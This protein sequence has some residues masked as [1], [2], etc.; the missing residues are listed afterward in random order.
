MTQQTIEPFPSV[1]LEST[2]SDPNPHAYQFRVH[3]DFV[4]I[5][6]GHW[7]T[8]SSLE[9]VIELIAVTTT[10]TTDT[11]PIASPVQGLLV[12]EA[13]PTALASTLVSIPLEQPVVPPLLV[14][15]PLLILPPFSSSIDESQPLQAQ[16][17]FA[18]AQK[19]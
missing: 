13:L 16:H 5:P 19:L 2:L 10:Q 7:Q 18:L 11:L 8:I 6:L 4:T 1:S 3:G 17:L 12:L 15:I 14:T 9:P